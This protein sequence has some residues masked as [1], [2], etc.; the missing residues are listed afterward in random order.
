MALRIIE[1]GGIT[2]AVEPHF[3]SILEEP[4]HAVEL[5]KAIPGMSLSLIHI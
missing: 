5:L 1:N 2:Y 3:G 4:K